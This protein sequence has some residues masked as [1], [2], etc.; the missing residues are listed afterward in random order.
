MGRQHLSV[1]NALVVGM[2]QWLPSHPCILL[3][4]QGVLKSVALQNVYLSGS[5][6]NCAPSHAPTYPN[7]GAYSAAFAAKY[8]GT[9]PLLTDNCSQR[10]PTSQHPTLA[11]SLPNLVL[12]G[13][14][15]HLHTN[16]AVCRFLEVLVYLNHCG[17]PS[18]ASHWKC[19]NHVS[20]HC[21]WQY[22]MQSMQR[23]FS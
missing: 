4:L 7:R 20:S 17:I 3:Q 9:Q 8:R 15:A 12:A 19:Q 6:L 10:L 23:S 13:K 1:S 5:S 14:T 16:L 21:L 11:S 18:M 22:L 2:Q